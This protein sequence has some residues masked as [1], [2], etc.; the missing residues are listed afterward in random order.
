MA[1]SKARILSSENDASV[2]QEQNTSININI[3]PKQPQ[4]V[5]Y[6]SITPI[7]QSSNQATNF[8]IP[9]PPMNGV[10]Q[11][12]QATNN[13]SL[14][15][16]ISDIGADITELETKNKFLE[17]L[18]SIYETNPIKVNDLLI[19]HSNTLMEL[20]KLLTQADKVELIVNDDCSCNGCVSHSKYLLIDRIL[21]YKN[22]ES[23]DL[24]YKY[25]NIYTELIRHNISLKLTI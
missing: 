10:Y 20:I 1:L 16:G 24:K 23:N 11:S 12:P 4:P 14:E 6:P 15:R 9:Q 18:L 5:E 22:N 8:T 17:I 7:P 13:V 3:K 19:C 21:V 25:N 2:K